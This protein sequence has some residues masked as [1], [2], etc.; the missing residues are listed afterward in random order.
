MKRLCYICSSEHELPF[1]VR[2]L[3]AFLTLSEYLNLYDALAESAYRQTSSNETS[4]TFPDLY[5]TSF[6]SAGNRNS[7]S[8]QNDASDEKQNLQQVSSAISGASGEGLRGNSTE[9]SAEDDASVAPL[10]A[11]DDAKIEDEKQHTNGDSNVA[12]QEEPRSEKQSKTESNTPLDAKTSS[13]EH[14]DEQDVNG[15]RTIEGGSE[16]IVNEVE[17]INGSEN[18]VLAEKRDEEEGTDINGHSL[19]DGIEVT[20]STAAF[21]SSSCESGFSNDV[22]LTMEAIDVSG[23]KVI[24]CSAPQS[25]GQQCNEE[26]NEIKRSISST[27]SSC[28][29]S[30]CTTS[31]SAKDDD[32]TDICSLVLIDLITKV[33]AMVEEENSDLKNKSSAPQSQGQQC[34]EEKN[35]IKRS[36]SSTGSSCNGSNC[37]TS[38][39]AKNDDDTD[40]C[41]LVLEDL[42]TKVVAMVE[43][44]NSDLRN[45][46]SESVVGFGACCQACSDVQKSRDFSN[47]SAK[48]CGSKE[49]E[50]KV[51]PNKSVTNGDSS[52]VEHDLETETVDST[53]D[54]QETIPPQSDSNDSEEA[55][56]S[57]SPKTADVA[58][59][60]LPSDANSSKENSL[61]SD[62]IRT[63]I[64]CDSF[65]I[66]NL[67]VGTEKFLE[68]SFACVD[69]DTDTEIQQSQPG[70]PESEVN[71]S[72]LDV[73]GSADAVDG[74]SMSASFYSIE[75]DSEIF[76]ANG[77]EGV[78]S[79]GG[80]EAPV[81]T[82]LE[83]VEEEESPEWFEPPL[84]DIHSS[85]LPDLEGEEELLFE[86]EGGGDEVNQVSTTDFVQ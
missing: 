39:S 42:I 78:S 4:G 52:S 19:T 51:A 57:Q 34:D 63:P 71:T 33:V 32:D 46:S 23:L 53:P 64:V 74:L 14:T 2:I 28:N 37:T 40:I 38:E 68:K 21:D 83:E 77:H 67:N 84:G 13:V 81:D 79:S 17:E 20:N 86:E 16:R 47:G 69:T 61:R 62:L 48:P 30:N 80:I 31:E 76:V 75:S 18:C 26:K 35:E 43:E 60:G 7:S 8:R 72:T 66:R 65:S 44:E 1:G 59:N 6:S 58:E 3:N 49:N 10:D 54:I 70:R 36:I 82:A 45:K 41:S 27:G 5:A 24:E 56:C 50:D 15:D 9:N 22:C 25:Q 11:A 85:S 29:G 12:D 55:S 73:N